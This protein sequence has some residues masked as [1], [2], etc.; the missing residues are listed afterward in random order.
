MRLMNWR[1]PGDIRISIDQRCVY[2]SMCNVLLTLIHDERLT[3]GYGE[4]E[5][6]IIIRHVCDGI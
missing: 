1:P 2:H 3:V 6:N 5:V 4:T